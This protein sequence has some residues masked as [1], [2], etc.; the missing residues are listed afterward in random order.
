MIRKR[1]QFIRETGKYG[2]VVL[3]LLSCLLTGCGRGEAPEKEQE[4]T[5]HYNADDGEFD[6]GSLWIEET[7]TMEEAEK[8]EKT[9][10]TLVT[11]SPKGS[12]SPY[13]RVVQAFNRQ[14]KDYHVEIINCDLGEALGDMRTRLGI[15]IGTGEGPDIMMEEVFPVNQE[16]IRSGAIVD[17]TSYLEESG[18]TE[19]KY[20][21][22]Y[23]SITAGDRIYGVSPSGMGQCMIV[24]ASLFGGKTNP[25]IEE[26][27]ESLLNY[28]GKAAFC[29]RL[30]GR[31]IMKYFL[32]GSRD[33]W[34]MVDWEERTC[35]F[36]GELF[37]NILDVVK[38]YTEGARKGYEPII[39]TEALSPGF[40][41]GRKAMEEEGKVVMG[42]LFDEGCFPEYSTYY[43]LVIN[44]N[45]KNL[46]GA[47]AFLSYTLSM[48]GQNFLPDPV[49]KEMWE[50]TV[51]YKIGLV[52][53][54]RTEGMVLDEEIAEEIRGLL[55]ESRNLPSET[56]EILKIVYG[57]SESYFDGDKSKEEVISIIENRVSLY[58]NE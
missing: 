35:D 54:G 26:F 21:P 17:L 1:S 19:E 22:M 4:I 44:S 14:S 45:T 15:E 52:E 16:I 36:S 25:T 6:P 20:F 48:A 46:E 10:L 30:E 53:A 31:R 11:T 29:L 3:A 40:Y 5:I 39:D 57:E 47:Y 32:A 41:P 42:Y 8:K 23:A 55:E 43:S 56:E 27:T 7:E 58:L 18:I 38:R 12:D 37:S 2:L 24:D 34:G 28:Q 9:T 33:L 50:K 51:K 13:A 49:N